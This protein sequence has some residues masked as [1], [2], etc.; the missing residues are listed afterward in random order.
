MIPIG[1][2]SIIQGAA[3]S[4]KPASHGLAGRL[5]GQLT[6][7]RKGMTAAPYPRGA[8]SGPYTLTWPAIGRSRTL[9]CDSETIF[10]MPDFWP[11]VD[12][13]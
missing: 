3:Q 6:P 1:N 4:G 10:V 5:N 12:S 8:R 11:S 7:Q 13:V 2:N 9:M